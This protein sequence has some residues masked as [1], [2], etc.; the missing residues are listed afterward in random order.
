MFQCNSKDVKYENYTFPKSVSIFSNNK[1]HENKDVI[2]KFGTHHKLMKNSRTIIFVCVTLKDGNNFHS[3][4]T[5]LKTKW[6]L[7][8]LLNIMCGMYNFRSRIQE[9][10]IFS[11]SCVCTTFCMFLNFMSLIFKIIMQELPYFLLLN[12]ILSCISV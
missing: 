10:I 12:F 3:F 8:L 7:F 11:Y 1:S 6:S 4:V 2:F 9:I 5:N